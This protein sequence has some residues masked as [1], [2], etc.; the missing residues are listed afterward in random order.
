MSGRTYHAL[1]EIMMMNRRVGALDVTVTGIESH[2]KEGP[3]REI[4]WQ[5]PERPVVTLSVNL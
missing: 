2:L 1:V 4:A 5:H 3:S